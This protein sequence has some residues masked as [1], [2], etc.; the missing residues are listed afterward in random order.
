LRQLYE[1]KRYEL[2]LEQRRGGGIFAKKED[3]DCYTWKTRGLFIGIADPGYYP[4]NRKVIP[5]HRF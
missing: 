5:K 4:S 3:P 2:Q 1:G